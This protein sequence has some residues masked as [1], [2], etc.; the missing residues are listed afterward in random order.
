MLDLSKL[1]ANKLELRAS[2]SDFVR[3]SRQLVLSFQTLA[4]QKGLQLE[5]QSSEEEIFMYFDDEKMEQILLNLVSNAIKFTPE[6]GNVKVHLTTSSHNT[7]CLEVVDTGV[8]LSQEQLP[9]IFDRFYQADSGD[10]RAFAGTGIGLALTK[11]LV[12]LHKGSIHAS[13]QKGAGTRM[14]LELLMGKDHLSEEQIWTVQTDKSLNSPIQHEQVWGLSPVQTEHHN[15]DKPLLLVADDHHELRQY[16]VSRLVPSFQTIEADNGEEAW[17]M[18]LKHTPDLIVSDVMM[19]RMSGYQLCE[20]IK[21]DIRT[22]HIPLILL[23]AK[24]GIDE[25]LKGLS[26]QADAY[27]TKPFNSQELRLRVENMISP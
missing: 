1:D 15:G 17:E 26:Y 16:I 9:H 19:P 6:G 2:Q 8:G 5:F 10:T 20:K 12:D 24:S 11:E 23:T 27:L 7:V 14:K 13:S 4:E 22:N 25:K 21:S 18:A 3:F